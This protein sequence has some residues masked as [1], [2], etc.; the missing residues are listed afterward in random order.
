MENLAI[1]ESF[2]EFKDEK[3]IDRVTLMSFIEEAFRVQLRKKFE[4]DENFDVIVNPDK[5]DLEIW[6]NR[7]IVDDKSI[8]DSNLEIAYSEAIK[9]E[10]DFEVGEEVSEEIKMIDLGRRFILAFRQTLVQKVQE[11]DSG[12]LYKRYK[13]MEGEIITG[14]VHHVRNREIIIYDDQQNELILRRDEMIPEKDFFRKGDTV[15]SIVKSVE[16]RGTKPFILLSRTA[17]NFLAKLFE[18]EIPEVFDGIITVKGVVR[19]PGEKAK[20]AVE[21]YDDRIDPVGACVG[22]KGSR[23]HGIVRELRSENIDVINFT[24]NQQLF[25]QRALSPAKI[26][27]IV[28]DEERKKVDVYLPAD[29]VSLAIGRGGTNIRLAS[30]LT[31]YEIDVYREDIVHEEDVELIEFSDE[32]EG[33][34]IEQLRKSGYD[35][36][37]SILNV[38]TEDIARRSDLEIETVEEV[39]GVLK[40][41]FED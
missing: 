13:D 29:Q 41:E 30:R 5:G 16:I 19:I 24:T 37:K 1:I 38:E 31:E 20:V 33:W 18:T 28:M 26:S 14:E 21:S 9:I 35:T 22:M 34:V 3:N 6:R 32:I 40:K 2:G 7:I 36:A 25:I 39:R 15:R 8:E 12:E 27:N 23:I 4:S 17:D 11:H 10:P